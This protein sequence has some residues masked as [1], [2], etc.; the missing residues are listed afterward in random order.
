MSKIMQLALVYQCEFQPLL[1]SHSA[2]PKVPTFLSNFDLRSS[3]KPGLLRIGREPGTT[4][5]LYS[6]VLDMDVYPG[7]RPCHWVKRPNGRDGGLRVVSLKIYAGLKL[8]RVI[9]LDLPD[10]MHEKKESKN[11]AQ[12]YAPYPLHSP[13]DRT[14]IVCGTARSCRIKSASHGRLMS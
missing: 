13:A 7:S 2:D 1:L 12:T 10:R 14:R 5:V 11:N 8:A 4:D 6:L 3:P 9:R